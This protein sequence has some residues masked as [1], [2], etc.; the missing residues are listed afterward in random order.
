MKFVD[1]LSTKL[2]VGKYLYFENGGLS[3]LG[4][5]RS[6]EC[7]GG[8]VCIRVPLVQINNKQGRRPPQQMS[9][10]VF[11]IPA[12]LEISSLGNFPLE[13]WP[14]Q[15]KFKA[16]IHPARVFKRAEARNK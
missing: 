11:R 16:S 14:N 15:G 9:D 13:P 7:E 12:E 3:C 10:Q 2:L 4:Q 6:V 5:I 8:F 1:V